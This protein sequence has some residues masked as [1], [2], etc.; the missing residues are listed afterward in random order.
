MASATE[1]DVKALQ[2]QLQQLRTDF[3]ALSETLKGLVRHGISETA[4]RA[5]APAEKAW[6]EVKRHAE[7]VSR[8]IE[9]KPM[10]AAFTALG[11]GFVFGV[12]FSGRRN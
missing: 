8:E 3:T 12:L 4:Q 5:S 7:T 10:T 11:V 9:E 2:D 1:A 6:A